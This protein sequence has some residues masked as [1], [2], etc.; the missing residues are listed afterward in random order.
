MNI[1]IIDADLLDNGTRHPNLALMKISGYYKERGNDVKLLFDY[2]NINDYDE[3]YLSKVFD[4]TKVP[5]N[6]NDYKNLHIGGTGIFWDEAPNLPYEI[7]HHMPDYSLYD[8]WIN[9]E[10]NRGIKR[11]YFL[12]YLDYSIG[13]ATRGC[14]RKCPF[15]VNHKYNEVLKH[16]TIKEFYDSSKKYIYL[17]DDNF[18]A[19]K[20]WDK[21][22]DE[23]EGIN[24][25]F[26]FRQGLDV[27]LLTDEKAKRLS[28]MKYKGDF[29]FA[30]DNIDDKDII[31]NKLKL[32][33]KYYNKKNNTKLYVLCG[34]DRNGKYDKEF[35]IQDIIDTLERIKILMEYG[36]VPYIMRYEK[37]EGSPY[38]GMYITLAR[39]CNQ[40]SFFKKESLN[41]YVYKTDGIGREDKM[42]AS[43]RYIE[44]FKKDYP[45]IAARYFDLKFENLN[46]YNYKM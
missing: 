26:Q 35:W 7:E 37:Y 30:F 9:K 19:Y 46:T 14:V 27:R 3:V 43:K 18:L 5:I 6:F 24:K 16:S 2:N 12:D 33:K 40:P 41:E 34:F 15:C 20:D 10:I 8:D 42:Y 36:C 39:W 23:I 28:K 17:W 4:F 29:I 11:T 1:G 25:P 38:K 21:I 13:F 32:W 22:L 45:D 44:D 31:I